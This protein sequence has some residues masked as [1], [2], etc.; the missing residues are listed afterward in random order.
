MTFEQ[1]V[2]TFMET[3]IS[4]GTIINGN[5]TDV[6]EQRKTAVAIVY[7]VNVS[8]DKVDELYFY[9]WKPAGATELSYKG[10]DRLPIRY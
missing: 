1:E 6:N 9:V 4:G 5:L 3:L 7:M 10:M 2:T 8:T